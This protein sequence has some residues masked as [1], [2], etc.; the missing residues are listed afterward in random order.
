MID[1]KNFFSFLKNIIMFSLNEK[2]ADRILNKNFDKFKAAF[3]TR[4]VNGDENYEF[5]EQLG[6]LSI[7]KFIVTYMG[8][9]FPQLRSSNSVG[10]LASLRILY[11]SK[12]T[13]SKLSEQYEFDKFIKC[14][15]EER[16]DKNKFR[17]ILEDVFEAFFGVVEFSIDNDWN[18]NGLGYTT[19]YRILSRI[20]DKQDISIEYENLVDAKTRLNELKDE[21]KIMLQYKDFKK[22]DGTYIT[23]VYVNNIFAGYG[24]SYI[25]K[26]S[27]IISAQKALDW[28][29]ENLGLKKIIPERYRILSNKIW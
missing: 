23:E 8:V 24:E 10:V 6:D 17:N 3:T 1:D 11:G 22:E 7:N 28:I 14:T 9:R 4:D 12:E 16:M 15:N 26:T 20:F 13:L 21:Y 27:Q 2:D 18:F 19:V 29:D 25:K 5:F